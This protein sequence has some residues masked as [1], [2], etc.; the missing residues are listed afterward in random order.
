MDCSLPGSS[1]MGLSKQEYWGEL[2]FP[3][4]GTPWTV[5]CQ[6]SLSMGLSRQ[7]YWSELPFPPPGIKPASPASAG[8]FFTTRQRNYFRYHLI[9]LLHV[10]RALR[11]SRQ[12]SVFMSST[13]ADSTNRIFA[14]WKIF[15]KK[16]QKAPK[17]KIWICC[18]MATTYIAFTLSQA[19]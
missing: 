10:K 4:P 3:T 18:T 1:V 11:R 9:S 7:E 16:I 6:A 13:S 8:G 17:T 5:A 2:L 12:P 14:I 19:L 15:R